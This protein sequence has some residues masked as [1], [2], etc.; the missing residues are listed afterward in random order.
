MFKLHVSFT[1]LF[2]L[3][4]FGY[5][6]L[7]LFCVPILFLLSCI[8]LLSLGQVHMFECVSNFLFYLMVSCQKLT[9]VQSLLFQAPW[10]IM[11]WMIE[12]LHRHSAKCLNL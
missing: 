7:I 9:E 12:N 11:I 4:E 8:Y 5:R 1:F 3:L 10:N 6:V 2:L